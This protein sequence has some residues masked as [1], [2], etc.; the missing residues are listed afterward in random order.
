[1][2]HSLPFSASGS[3]SELG[4]SLL[5]SSL[6]L[7]SSVRAK[8]RSWCAIIYSSLLRAHI[9]ERSFLTVC[10]CMCVFPA[11]AHK[12]WRAKSNIPFTSIHL[13]SSL[14]PAP[15]LTD[16]HTHTHTHTHTLNLHRQLSVYL[17]NGGGLGTV[18][19]LFFPAR[20]L[21]FS[22]RNVDVI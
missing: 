5:F 7:L 16:K 4:S 1:M 11:L 6:H 14:H 10:V 3:F 8:K 15:S 19:P 12:T 18:C 9:L 2:G 13:V 17:C 22:L 21:V 20:H